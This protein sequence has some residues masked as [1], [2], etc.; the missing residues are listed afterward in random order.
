MRATLTVITF[1]VFMLFTCSYSLAEENTE[2]DTIIED[3]QKHLDLTNEQ[4]ENLKPIIKERHEQLK[5]QLDSTIE[6]GITGFEQLSKQLKDVST[7]LEQKAT[8]FLNSD[9]MVQL[10]EYLDNLNKESIAATKDSLINDFE[11]LLDLTEEQAKKA[12]PAFDDFLS[13]LSGLISET[14][15]SGERNLEDFKVKLNTLRDRLRDKLNDILNEQQMKKFEE[16]ESELEKG[17][18]RVIFAENGGKQS[19]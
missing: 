13:Q 11:K 3:I 4:L 6:Q 15:Q 9:E 1:T 17:I 16:H 14:M 2:T 10:K 8:E 18:Q 7:Q 19:V 5:K 12:G